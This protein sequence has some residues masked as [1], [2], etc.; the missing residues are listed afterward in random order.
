MNCSNVKD[1]GSAIGIA[2]GIALGIALV[3]EY[4]ALLPNSPLVQVNPYK[5]S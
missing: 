4:C 2:V 3:T 1:D 5:L